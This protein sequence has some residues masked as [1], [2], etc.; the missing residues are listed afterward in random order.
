MPGTC[1]DILRDVQNQFIMASQNLGNQL[2]EHEAIAHSQC[3]PLVLFIPSGLGVL[4]VQWRGRLTRGNTIWRA[5]T[6]RHN[7][8]S[9]VVRRTQRKLKVLR[10]NGSHFV[11]QKYNYFGSHFVTQKYTSLRSTQRK[12]SLCKN[13]VIERSNQ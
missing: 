1:L 7:A 13:K 4:A 6:V 11:T 12:L 2:V 5:V 3:L 10:V 8:I 9:E